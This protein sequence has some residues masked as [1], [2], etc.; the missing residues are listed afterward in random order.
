MKGKQ[1]SI[2]ERERELKRLIQDAEVLSFESSLIQNY[3]NQLSSVQQE[4]ERE[5]AKKEDF[6][7]IE[8]GLIQNAN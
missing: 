1:L 2:F 5:K 8:R 7:R 6:K 4:I 3:K